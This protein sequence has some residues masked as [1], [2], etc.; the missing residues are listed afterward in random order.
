[1]RFLEREVF[2]AAERGLVVDLLRLPGRKKAEQMT[3]I[4][5][6]R[7]ICGVS[8]KRLTKEGKVGYNEIRSRMSRRFAHNA[9]DGSVCFA[10]KGSRQFDGR[11]VEIRFLYGNNEYIIVSNFVG[12]DN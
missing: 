10:V 8:C 4:V 7:Y 5:V 11:R 6:H 2:A 3:K 1:M 12:T 9:Q